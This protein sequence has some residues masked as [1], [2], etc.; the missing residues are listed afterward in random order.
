MNG[1]VTSGELYERALTVCERHGFSLDGM[2][3]YEVCG[4]MRI[5]FHRDFDSNTIS[6][7]VQGLPSDIPTEIFEDLLDN[8]LRTKIKRQNTDVSKKTKSWLASYKS[9]R[10]LA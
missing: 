9:R 4:S 2:E 6:L 5:N 10:A 1:E 8:M 7:N 3:W